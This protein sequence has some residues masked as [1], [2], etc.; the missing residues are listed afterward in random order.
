[1]QNELLK[2]MAKK[3]DEQQRYIDEKLEKRD[4][5][6]MEAIRDMQEE[7]RVLLETAAASRDKKWY[8]FW[9]R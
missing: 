6:L 2:S 9:E 4:Y 5:Q 7:K 3:L 8:K 1:Q